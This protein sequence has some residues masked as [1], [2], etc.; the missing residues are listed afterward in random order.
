MLKKLLL[1]TFLPIII[2]S[3][4]DKNFFSP[5]E[6]L[7]L[8]GNIDGIKAFTEKHDKGA[9]QSKK[10]Q[11]FYEELKPMIGSALNFIAKGEKSGGEQMK[12]YVEN[13]RQAE[14]TFKISFAGEKAQKAFKLYMKA[15]D[16]GNT[17][18]AVKW[19]K[20]AVLLRHIYVG[21]T[22][23]LA[24]DGYKKASDQFRND[25][26]DEAS[27]TINSLQFDSGNDEELQKIAEDIESLKN[28]IDNRILNRDRG[29]EVLKDYTCPE[30]DFIASLSISVT[31]GPSWNIEQLV[32]HGSEEDYLADLEKPE[33]SIRFGFSFDLQYKIIENLYL[34]AGFNYNSFKYSNSSTDEWISADFNIS[35]TNMKVYADYLFRTYAG[36][37]PYVEVGGGFASYTR[38][39][40]TAI[41][42]AEAP[43]IIFPAYGQK[44]EIE[45]Q[46]F[47]RPFVI[48]GGGTQ[49]I[50]AKG[51][52]LVL[53][54]KYLFQ[55]DLGDEEM[56]NKTNHYLG[57]GLGIHF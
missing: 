52:P 17:V 35:N 9:L 38:E 20:M 55:L 14:S 53:T 15:A 29:E 40:F 41:T 11:T 37:R 19:Y 5:L 31:P 6:D 51:F 23:V 16:K 28:N 4:T 49:Y 25:A 8:K 27:K 7:L 3:Q 39:E 46:E 21:R 54:A 32:L 57:V 13:V 1:F 34:G 33:N 22:K 18:E 30:H 48:L 12:S 10:D 24:K 26:L 42:L 2:L 50:P 44:W 47:S 43:G 56:V 36:V 45:K